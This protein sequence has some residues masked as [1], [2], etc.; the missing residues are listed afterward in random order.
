MIKAARNTALTATARAATIISCLSTRFAGRTVTTLSATR[1]GRIP[2]VFRPVYQKGSGSSRRA[3]ARCARRHEG[4]ASAVLPELIQGE[5][6]RTTRRLSTAAALCRETTSCSWSTRCRPAS[7]A[8]SGCS[9]ASITATPDLVSQGLGGGPP[10][11][12]V[13]LGENVRYA[14]AGRARLTFG[15]NPS[16]APAPA[17]CCAAW[18]ARCFAKESK[19]RA[20][21]SQSGCLRCRASNASTA[22]AD[23][24]RC[25]AAWTANRLGRGGLPEHGLIILTARKSWM[26]R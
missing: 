23:A 12:A 7:G 22:R 9:A 13:L 19:K 15:G 11:G 26:R 18:T 3:M 16:R 4:A 20:P 10:I 17:R 2:S 5:G 21:I 1:T 6:G 8:R 24:R 14:R 25:S